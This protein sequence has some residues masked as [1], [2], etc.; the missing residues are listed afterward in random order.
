MDTHGTSQDTMQG[1]IT[2]AHARQLNLQ[3][4]SVLSTSLCVF[5]NRLLANDLIKIRNHGEDQ[6]VLGDRLAS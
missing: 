6:E 5:Q 4:S 1:P 2:R 3:V